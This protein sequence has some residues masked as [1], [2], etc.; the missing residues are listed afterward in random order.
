MSLPAVYDPIA[1]ARALW[2]DVYFYDKQQEIIYSVLNNDETVVP[3]GN[4]LGKDFV[5]GFT[6][7][8]FFLTRQ[9]CRIVTTSAKDD[10]LRVLWGEIGR[11]IQTSAHPLDSRKGGPLIINHQDIR[12]V[13]GGERC[14][15]SYIKGMVA[16]E[17]TIA[18]MQGHHVAKTGDKIPRTLFVSDESSSVPDQ[19]MTMARTWCNRALVLGNTWP[20]S[21]FFYQAVKGKPG[22]DD[23][24]GDRPAPRKEGEPQ[25]YYRKIIQIKARHSPNVRLALAQIRQGIEPTGEMLVPGVKDWEEYQKNLSEWD[26][27][28][29][30]VSL[31]AEFYEGAGLYLFPSIW[32]DKAHKYWETMLRGKQRRAEA[33]GVDPAEGGDKTAFA[34]VDRYGLIELVSLKT[35]DTSVIPTLTLEFMRRHGLSKDKA[36]RVVFDLGGGG[37]PHVDRLRQMGYE[38]RGVGF[39]EGVSIPPQRH[40]VL[41]KERKEVVEDRYVY[42]NRRAEMYGGLSQRM[43]PSNYSK[44]TE[45]FAIPVGS[46]YAELRHQLSKFP[47]TYDQE[48]RLKLPPKNKRESTS[49][50]VCLIDLI[51]HSPDE[52]DALA[53]AVWGLEDRAL[54]PFVGI[55]G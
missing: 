31:E 8:W 9:P 1:F 38:V 35:P 50:E 54:Q 55:A 44:D 15:I 46:I 25:R 7:L 24:G 33:I 23:L 28:Q 32:M 27:V 18:A 47:K 43:D 29:K 41:F 13:V 39:G 52:A 42:K 40:K 5:A 12:K 51:G 11:F 22:T 3:A 34:A 6:V 21:N 45:G 19:Y 10:H 17:D 49:K 37:K 48:G 14:P 36:H 26:E 53:L 4:M 20:C 16:S 30:Q 2:P